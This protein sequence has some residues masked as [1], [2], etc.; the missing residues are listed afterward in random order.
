MQPG[1]FS[2]PSSAGYHLKCIT[3]TFPIVTLIE[4][5]NKNPNLD[6]SI[7]CFRKK[8][9]EQEKEFYKHFESSNSEDFKAFPH[10]FSFCFQRIRTH[11]T[12]FTRHQRAL[13]KN[14]LKSYEGAGGI[15]NPFSNRQEQ[16]FPKQVSS[17][18]RFACQKDP[19]D[20]SCVTPGP[21]AE[22]N[23]RGWQW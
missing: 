15:A 17:P 2:H 6:P 7:V 19:P 11:K 8:K 13:I 22:V 14:I 18:T 5:T 9:K 10:K 16:T 21:S 4:N 3:H 1:N 12:V 20:P 23:K